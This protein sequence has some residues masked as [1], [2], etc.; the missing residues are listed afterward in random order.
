MGFFDRDRSNSGGNQGMGGNYNGK[1]SS[2]ASPSKTGL[3]FASPTPSTAGNSNNGNGGNGNSRAA[4][5]PAPL[6]A[7][8]ALSA[9]NKA[10]Q[11]NWKAN[12]QQQL[13]DYANSALTDR[14]LIDRADF[15]SQLTAKA[16][17]GVASRS[18]SRSGVAL[19][20]QAAKQSARLGNINTAQYMDQSKNSAVLAQDD[21]NTQA[22]GDSLNA[23]T[24]LGQT[25]S[26]ALR[27]A[28][29]LE[30]QRIAGDRQRKGA[31]DASNMSMASGLASM[32]MMM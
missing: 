25:G 21:R 23:Y 27:N 16:A 26:D 12:F 32:Y 22:V 17:K 24:Q 14:T 3:T 10:A 29:G 28:A 31:A 8:A 5:A 19:T 4:A 18:L 11:A 2:L 13:D 9:D 7:E 6:S 15:N 30:S 20:G 1:S